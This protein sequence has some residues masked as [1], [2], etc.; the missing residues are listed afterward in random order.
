MRGRT[1]VT[2]IVTVS[3]NDVAVVG[4]GPVGALT[5]LGLAQR[6]HQV[7]LLESAPELAAEPRAIV[8]YWHILEGLEALGVLDDIDAR[9]V[10]N[11][12]FQNRVLATGHKAVVS[13]EPLEAITPRPWN[14]HLGQHEVTRIALEHLGRLPN[15][16][17]RLGAP[18]TGVR[19][20]E[21]QVVLKVAGAY[22]AEERASWVIAADGARSTVRPSLGLSFHGMTWA[23][24]F[25]ATDLR[26]PFDQAGLGNANMVMDPG[27]GCVIARIDSSLWRWTWSESADLPVE[28]VADRLPGR[29][30]ALGLPDLPYEVVLAQPYRMHQRAADRM[31]AGRVLLVGDAAHATN[32]TGGLGLT[33]GM[34]D[35]FALL[36]PLDA[37]IRGGDDAPLDAWA[38]ERLRIFNEHASPMAVDSKHRVYDETDQA[39]LERFIQGAAAPVARDEAVRRLSAMTVLR[40][41]FPRHYASLA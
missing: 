23:D 12:A 33:S 26:Y 16:T 4:A 32:P 20:D 31:R 13:L 17:L 28:T 35:L 8:Y 6:G 5:A 18:V 7:L 27:N 1:G 22:P 29:L 10:R 39:A 15:A 30:A 24:R 9:G 40:S 14:I 21:E 11:T 34:Y 36:D 37:V 25:V 41:G 3:T 19:Q 2:S 38:A